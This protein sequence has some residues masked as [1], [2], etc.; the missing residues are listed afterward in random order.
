[1]SLL[2]IK[3]YQSEMALF[4]APEVSK[5]VRRLGQIMNFKVIKFFQIIVLNLIF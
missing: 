1:M 3:V 5:K 2:Q 4:F